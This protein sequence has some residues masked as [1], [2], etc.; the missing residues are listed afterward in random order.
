[1]LDSSTYYASRR[2]YRRRQSQ[3]KWLEVAAALLAGM[4]I[5][6]LIIHLSGPGYATDFTFFG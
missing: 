4:G 3:F 5:V 6:A 1:M 2:A